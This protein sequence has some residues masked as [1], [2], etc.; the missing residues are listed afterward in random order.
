MST[1]VK[2]NEFPNNSTTWCKEK[3]QEKVLMDVREKIDHRL[4]S[5]MIDKI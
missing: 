5:M 3:A 4:A 2:T 1:T